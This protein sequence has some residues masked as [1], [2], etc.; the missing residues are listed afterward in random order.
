MPF[1]PPRSRLVAPLA[2][3]VA[4]LLGLSG[5][6]DDSGSSST[7]ADATTTSIEIEDVDAC[8][9]IDDLAID[10]V[11]PDEIPEPEG[12][13]LGNGAAECDWDGE[14]AELL[15]SVLPAATFTADYADRITGGP[16]VSSVA[17]PEDAVGFE[18]MVGIERSSGRG[19]TVGFTSDDLGVMV[20]VRTGEEGDPDTDLAL[21]T[22]V[23]EAIAAEV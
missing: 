15:V 23:A 14:D 22:E 16:E 17:L 4:T 8:A 21:A 7:S 5:C 18:G 9:L 3:S 12:K 11:F 2:V 6:G 13:N 20:A 19:T 10:D 1:G